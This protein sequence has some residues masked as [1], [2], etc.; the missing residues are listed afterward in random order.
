[1]WRA[2]LVVM[3]TSVVPV[4]LHAQ[5]SRPPVVDGDRVRV[6]TPTVEGVFIVAASGADSLALRPTMGTGAPL[7][8]AWRDVTSLDVRRRRS[9]GAG[10]LRGAGIGGLVGV[11]SGVTIGFA[12]GSDDPSTFLAFS[13]GEKAAVLGVALGGLGA[14]VGGV[15]GL[16]APGERWDAL[17]LREGVRVSPGRGGGLTLS[18]AARF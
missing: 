2:L 6:I 11:L 16:V 1:M 4:A 18:Y 13:A 8:V 9:S 3:C 10:G 12:S 5:A 7:A 14:V 17:D 15:I